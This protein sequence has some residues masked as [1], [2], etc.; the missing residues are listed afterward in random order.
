MI[1][2]LAAYLLVRLARKKEGR[3]PYAFHDTQGRAYYAW[4]DYADLPRRRRLLVDEVM[5][6]ID[7]GRPRQSIEEIGEAIAKQ[8]EAAAGAKQPSD[9]AKHLAAIAAM[10]KELL[11]R[12]NLV[13]EECYYALAAATCVREDEGD[14][15]V[16]DPAIHTEKIETFRSAGRAGHRFFTTPTLRLLLGVAYTT[17]GNWQTLLMEWISQGGREEATLRACGVRPAE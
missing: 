2:Q 17:E 1:R 11:V 3:P 8:A 10:S 9:R 6:W 16:V 12:T 15:S 13:P 14:P 7:A 4:A 5:L